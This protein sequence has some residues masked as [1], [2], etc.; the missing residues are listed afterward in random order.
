MIGDH[1]FG[2]TMIDRLVF[3]S[4]RLTLT[5]GSS[6]RIGTPEPKTDCAS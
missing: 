4:H 5:G 6:R 1:T 2:D 3:H